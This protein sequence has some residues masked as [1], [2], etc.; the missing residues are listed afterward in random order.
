FRLNADGSLDPTFGTST[1]TGF[2]SLGFGDIGD[3]STGLLAEPDGPV[4]ICGTRQAPGGMGFLARY[5]ADGSHD[6]TFGTN[7]V[8]HQQL[9]GGSGWASLVDDGNGGYYTAG[10][11]GGRNSDMAVAEFDHSGHLVSSFGM[12]GVLT[13][14]T[15]AGSTSSRANKLT[16]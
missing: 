4:V 13:V 14:H 5:N 16:L 8:V 2:V 6:T 7:G 3:S 9:L 15:G 11:A 12:N 10:F 1:T